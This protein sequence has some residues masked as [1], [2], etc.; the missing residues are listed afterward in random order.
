MRI[1]VVLVALVGCGGDKLTS[2][3]L[4]KKLAELSADDMK[5]LCEDMKAHKAKK[6]VSDEENTKIGCNAQVIFSLARS[7]AKDDDALRAECKKTRDTCMEKKE[8]MPDKDIDCSDSKFTDQMSGCDATVGQM[9]DCVT[10]MAAV[11]KKF[12]S[13]DTCATMKVGDKDRAMA[14]LDKMKSP[15][16][17]VMEKC[18]KKGGKKSAKAGGGNTQA[19]EALVKVEGFKT[20]MCECKDKACADGVNTAMTKWATEM[21][22]Q[23]NNDDKPDADIAK[24]M[25]DVMGA[26]TECMTKLLMAGAPAPTPP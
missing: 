5:K 25:T 21:A 26:Y 24:K 7:E 6:V 10:D 17:E 9:V 3:S 14:V 2:V 22:K 16:C 8:K 4:D 15:K 1:L 19:K 20:Q 23:A 12:A 18:G 13:E 11:M